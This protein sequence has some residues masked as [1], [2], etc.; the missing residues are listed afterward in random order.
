MTSW[1]NWELEDE[2]GDNPVLSAGAFEFTIEYDFEPPDPG[3]MYDSNG[4]GYP[5]H[6]ASITITNAVC[7]NL[8]ETI[9]GT[10]RV[11]SP[12][13]AVALSDWFWTVLDKQP[14]IRHEIEQSGIEQMMLEPDYDDVD[15]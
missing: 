7:K 15:D 5:G 9:G 4:D 12:E 2:D 11:P 14:K 1:L 13:E 8:R 3:Y 6:D 10:W